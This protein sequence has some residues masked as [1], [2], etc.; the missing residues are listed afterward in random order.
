MMAY[1][2]LFID[3]PLA[4]EVMEMGSAPPPTYHV[5]LPK[6][7]TL[8]DCDGG[9]VFE[10]PAGPMSYYAISRGQ[11]HC[12][13]SV[14]ESDYEGIVAAL[15]EWR[16]SNFAVPAWAMNCRSRRAFS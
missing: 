16:V 1:W 14:H 15:K 10:Q 5:R 11:T 4:G 13:Y 2:A 8:C 12:L 3:G 6:R 9:E 7:R